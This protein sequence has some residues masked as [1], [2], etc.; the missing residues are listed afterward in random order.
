[1]ITENELLNELIEMERID[2]YDP[3][4]DITARD[5]AEAVGVG[6]RR[7]IARLRELEE[8]GKLKSCWVRM[9]DGRRTVA[10]RRP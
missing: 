8:Q 4:V 6:S 2:D 5:Y 9:P 3:K 10:F 1:M 7:A